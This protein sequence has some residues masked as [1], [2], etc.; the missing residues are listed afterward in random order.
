MTA[1]DDYERQLWPNYQYIGSCDESGCGSLGLE[2]F[3]SVV[4][5]PPYIDYKNLLPGLNDSKQKTPQQRLELY[6]KIKQ[7]ALDYS[8][9]TASVQEIDELNIY[10]AKFLAF[11]RAIDSLTIKPDYI[12]IDGDKEIPEIKIEQKALV[13]GDSL[14][15]SIAAASILAKVDHDA[16]VDEISKLVHPDY[17]WNKNKTYYSAEHIAALKKHGKTQW[18]REKYVR[19]FL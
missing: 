10:W 13:K 11:R 18:H 8:V 5:F 1:N 7:Y 15:I 19:K 12:L 9:A 3:C 6:P 14:S 2:V 4:I 16:R 17:E